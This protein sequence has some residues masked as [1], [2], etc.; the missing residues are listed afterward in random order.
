MK[1]HDQQ[2]PEVKRYIDEEGST[3]Y[4]AYIIA[5]YLLLISMN[6]VKIMLRVVSSVCIIILEKK[7][8]RKTPF[9][10]VIFPKIFH[11][12]IDHHVKLV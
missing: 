1:R 9:F 4:D 6:S 10:K 5:T 2:H 11:Y 12:F 8:G 3:Q 7:P